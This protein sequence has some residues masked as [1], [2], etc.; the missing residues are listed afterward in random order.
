MKKSKII[1]P[2][3]LSILACGSVIAGS[4]YALFTS[5]SSVNV[6][7][8]SGKVDV[9]ASI[10]DL[11][12]YSPTKISNDGTIS[13]NSNAASNT[14]DEKVFFNGGK[15]S[16]KEDELNLENVTPGD[17]VSFK[18]DVKNDSTVKA[19]YRIVISC[20]EDNGLFEG[21]DVSFNTKDIEF[22]QNL[23]G[24]T[25]VSKY[26]QIDPSSETKSIDVSIELPTTAGN[27]Y[28]GKKSKI[29]CKVEA[30]QANAEV[31]EQE[32]KTLCL[33]NAT[34]LVNYGKLEANIT[35]ESALFT[36]GFSTIKLMNDVDMKGIEWTPIITRNNLDGQDIEISGLTFDGGNHTI[37]N[38]T[39]N[40]VLHSKFYYSGFFGKLVNTNVYNLNFNNARI[41]STHYAGVVAGQALFTSAIKNC[42]V[43]NSIVITT[44]ENVTSATHE[45]DNG[46][47]AGGIVGQ[48]NE[49]ESNSGIYNCVVENCKISGYRD[50]GGLAGYFDSTYLKDNKV[51]DTNIYWD[52]R[53]NYRKFE[54]FS[55]EGAYFGKIY[56]RP[57]TFV[58]NKEISN[59]TDSNVNIS[60][61]NLSDLNL[62]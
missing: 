60:N 39:A 56:G 14:N 34:D 26:I 31:K 19:L 11:N 23:E 10:K 30:I 17:K 5:E 22:A 24:I 37:S 12:V 44:P 59:N 1:I 36:G 6:A 48:M 16:L 18:I 27:K 58:Y 2:A 45:Y 4:T 3:L 13:D 49:G 61:I 62:N 40:E 29:I 54:S 15:A 53:I 21:L 43:T 55:S 38:L 35:T 41:T 52:N 57:S 46:D 42:K 28:Q 47:K 7:I 33:Y 20:S 9:K 50:V 32:E 8:S 51:S 25:S